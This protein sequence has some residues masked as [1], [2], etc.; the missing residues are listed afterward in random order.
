M[1]DR[2]DGKKKTGRA[3]RWAG[4]FAAPACDEGNHS[5]TSRAGRSSDARRKEGVTSVSANNCS[6]ARSVSAISR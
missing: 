2:R 3:S 1:F 6:L 4:L 5:K